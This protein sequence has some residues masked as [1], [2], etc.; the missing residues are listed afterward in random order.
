MEANAQRVEIKHSAPA[1]EMH[2]AAAA[3][4][5]KKPEDLSAMPVVMVVV[6]VVHP[7]VVLPLEGS[8]P[9]DLVLAV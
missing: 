2:N 1:V 7:V 3:V 5:E 6:R 9:E 4:L 8:A